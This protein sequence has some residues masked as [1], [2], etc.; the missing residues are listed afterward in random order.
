MRVLNLEVHNEKWT[1]DF[2]D[3]VNKIKGILLGNFIEAHHIGSTAI[4]GIKAK[5]VIDILLEVKSLNKVDECDNALE[6][7]GYEIMGEYGIQGRR[8]LKKG[9]EIRT[10]HL[11]VYESGNSEIER[12]RLFV[13]FMNA[14]P[15]KATKYEKLKIKLISLYSEL[16]DKYSQG[17]FEFIQQ[18]DTEVIE[19]NQE[20]Q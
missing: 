19:W 15:N 6:S 11:H 16:P 20:K 7:L 13:D 14:H 10:H 12:H 9:K 8:F 5:P 3:E 4:L 2:D 18:M 1:E 17:K